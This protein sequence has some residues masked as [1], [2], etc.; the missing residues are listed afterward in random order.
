MAESREALEIAAPA[1][2][3]AQGAKSFKMNSFRR[4][5]PAPIITANMDEMVAEA[6][7]VPRHMTQGSDQTFFPSP[8]SVLERRSSSGSST[9][10]F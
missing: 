4:H 6:P 5:R 9:S 1:Q 2:N 7:E 3:V 10:F 8:R